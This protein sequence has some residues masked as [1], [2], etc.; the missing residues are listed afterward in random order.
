MFVCES[1]KSSMQ[2]FCNNDYKPWWGVSNQILRLIESS[3]VLIMQP[4]IPLIELDEQQ[5][6]YQS[7][8]T[9]RPL[10]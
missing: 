5:V 7:K 8:V 1:M 9:V 2:I 10:P 4:S 6:E 3:V